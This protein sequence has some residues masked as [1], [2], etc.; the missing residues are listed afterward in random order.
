MPGKRPP[1]HHHRKQRNSLACLQTARFDFT[2]LHAS[3]FR[4]YK[5][6]LGIPP[7][8]SFAS[9]LPIQES[10]RRHCACLGGKAYKRPAWPPDDEHHHNDRLWNQ[11]PL[12]RRAIPAWCSRRTPALR[13][14]CPRTPYP[15]P[16]CS[17]TRPWPQ[18]LLG[19]GQRRDARAA[20]VKR[21]VFRLEGPSD[22]GWNNSF[23]SFTLRR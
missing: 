23:H 16:V 11:L 14:P 7:R 22:T 4:A 20:C 19:A 13:F 15:S 8:R 21:F 1:P 3:L 12:G 17:G 5:L 2:T 10:G 6:V 9:Q 18:Q